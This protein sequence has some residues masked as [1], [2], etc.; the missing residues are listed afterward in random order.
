MRDLI[1]MAITAA[2]C[3]LSPFNP[4][5]GLYGY[6]WFAL[7]RPDIL[8]WS[9]PNRYSLIIAVVTLA[10]N[11]GR[12]L[13]NFSVLLRNP[14]CR[15]LLLLVAVISLSVPFAVKPELCYEQYGLFM[16]MIVMALLIPMVI[17]GR[18]ELETL[19]VVLAVSIG[20][21]AGK[22]GLSGLLAGGA[23]FAQGYGGMLSDNNTMALAFVLA[24][25]LCWFARLI[26]EPVWARMGLA[27]LALLSAGGVIF[28]HSRG[29]ALATGVAL[30]LIAW[31]AKHRMLVGVL[32]LGFGAMAAYI[33]K[34]S[35]LSRMSTI[36][37]LS[38]VE[39]E[40]S[41][42][43]RITLAYA[44]VKMSLDYPLL[45]VGFTELNQRAL[46]ES[47]LP[48]RYK[49]S[50]GDK[51]IHNTYLQILVDSGFM[52]LLLYCWLLFGAI[53]KM[54]KSIRRL[55]IQKEGKKAAAIPLALQTA[56]LTYVVGSSFLSRS[57]FDFFY[58]LVMVAATWLE[59]ERT[60]SGP[61]M[62]EV[63]GA[64]RTVSEAPPETAE[65]TPVA[66]REKGPRPSEPRGGS[67]LRMGRER[68]ELK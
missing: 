37:S 24:V 3:I 11:S 35:F 52:A 5:L 4:R 49:E 17:T 33:V 48:Q 40:A 15:I 10:A 50:D 42:R 36:T 19:M 6:Y 20:F 18:K 58:I 53:W 32:V 7:M 14:L 43:S 62:V 8:A 54:E 2:L 64:Y 21:L 12:A 16:R 29:G 31:R 30:M 63:A 1:V 65:V 46:L 47:Y 41:A 60:G 13:M 51:V 22:A 23:R 26:V 55:S 27:A 56:L 57:S 34:D 68:R 66:P 44:A 67:R 38:S 61:E 9:G 59:V 39:Q 28:T 45:G 25:P